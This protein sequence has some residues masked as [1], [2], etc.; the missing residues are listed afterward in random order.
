MPEIK[1]QFTGGKMNKDVDERL[2]PK[3][4]YRDAMNIQVSTSEGSDVGAVQN[5]LG[6]KLIDGLGFLSGG[7]TCVGAI[8]D[9]KN[10]AL[11]WFVAEHTTNFTGNSINSKNLILQ[12]K[13]GVVTPV[14]VDKVTAEI[15][16]GA[17]MLAP[18]PTSALTIMYL[19]PIDPG[20]LELVPG[21]Y[22]HE[23]V[24]DINSDGNYSPL[25][26][27]GNVI[28]VNYTTGAV[29]IDVGFTQLLAEVFNGQI[30]QA[31]FYVSSNRGSVLGFDKNN[32][33]T[34]I[35][36]ID[37]MLFW[38]DGI[39]EPK[40]INI[41]RSIAGTTNIDFST[42]LI[43]DA[44]GITLGSNILAREE[45][46]TV[47]KK[48]PLRA[49]YLYMKAARGGNSRGTTSYNFNS[50]SPSDTIT[51][52]IQPFS[53]SS[54]NYQI[55]DVLLL[56]QINNPVAA[57]FPVT[58]FDIRAV[59]ISISGA[60]VN[61]QVLSIPN[62]L[63]FGSLVFVVDLDE[64]YDKLYALKF[65]R[66]A[67]RYKYEDNEYSS[68]GPFSEVAFMPGV[69]D[70][71][72]NKGYNLG[73]ENK[74]R[75]L[76]I[77][78]LIPRNIPMDVVE[79]DILYRESDSPNIYIVDEIKPSDPQWAADSYKITSETIKAA[80]PSNQLLR[81]WD[82]VPKKALAQEMTGNRIVY[83]N[84]EQN[85]DMHAYRPSLDVA[86]LQRVP[87]SNGW[88]VNSFLK[89]IKSLRDYQ[90][91]VVFSDAYGR[92]TPV[93]TDSAGSIKVSK[94]AASKSHQIVLQTTTPPPEWAKYQ[95][96]YIKETSTEYYN[97]SLD[98]Y[99]EAEDGNVW[100]SFPSSDR[101]KVDLDSSLYLKKSFNSAEAGFSTEKY[102]IIDIN[103]EAPEFIKTRRSILGK[104]DNG[105]DN[106]L[107]TADAN[108]PVRY[109]DEFT[110]ES[111]PLKNTILENF[112]KRHNSAD[113]GVGGSGGGAVV[114]N[115]LF[116]RITSYT[117]DDVGVYSPG[118]LATN[119]YEIDNVKKSEDNEEYI[120]RVKEPFGL[121]ATWTNTGASGN[122]ASGMSTITNDEVGLQFEIGQD[123]VQ[124]KA[125][126]QGRF[127][128]KIL[129]DTAVED[130]IIA[131]AM[132]Q[133]VE[134]LATAR[135]GYLKDFTREDLGITNSTSSTLAAHAAAISDFNVN[136]PDGN[137]GNYSNPEPDGVPVPTDSYWSWRA[138][139]KIQSKLNTLESRWVIDEAFATGEEPFWGSAGYV[140]SNEQADVMWGSYSTTYGGYH[141]QSA[142]SWTL[143][144]N[145]T[146]GPWNP[147]GLASS[148]VQGLGHGTNLEDYEYFTV[149]NGVTDHTIDISY[150]GTGRTK[151]QGYADIYEDVNASASDWEALVWHQKAWSTWWEISGSSTGDALDD[152]ARVFADMLQPGAFLRFKNDPNLIVYEIESVKKIFKLNYAEGKED[153]E[154]PFASSE[155]GDSSIPNGAAPGANEY[156]NRSHLNRRI[157]YRLKLTAP[158]AGDIIGTNGG[159]TGP[160]YD[161]LFGDNTNETNISGVFCPIEIVTLHSI[162][163][164]GETTMPEDPA[165]FE[166]V[167]K[168]DTGLDIYHEASDTM[169]IDLAFDP[170]AFAPRG[171]RVSTA[172]DAL[173]GN[174]ISGPATVSGWE[175]NLLKISNAYFM[176]DFL[177]Q[178][179]LL[180][181]TRPDGSY[182][183]AIIQGGL[184]E[185]IP[186]QP[187]SSY[188]AYISQAVGGNKI[189]IGWHNCYAFGNGVESNRIRDTFNKPFIDNGAKVSTTLEGGYEKEHRRYGLIY[190]GAYN[191]TSS[192]NNL[193]QFIAAEKITKDIN[194]IYGSIQK[195]YS[196]WGQGGDLIALCEDRILKILANKDALFNADG[197]PQLTSTNN[198]LGQAIPYSGEY[199]ISENPESFASEAYRIYFTDKV[200][201]A[202]MRLSMDGLTPISNHGMKDWFRDNLKLSNKIIGSYDD[203]KDEYNLTLE[204]DPAVID[205]KKP[206]YPTTVTFRED[207]KGWVSFKSFTPE[208]AISCA[209]EYYTFEK[210]KMWQ[211]HI[212]SAPCNTFNNVRR[213]SSLVAILNDIPGSIK[214][215]TTLN[216]EGTQARVSRSLDAA[217][218]DVQDGEYYNL[219]KINGWFVDY[220]ETE[221]DSGGV[222]EFRKKEH[223]WF[224]YIKGKEGVITNFVTNDFSGERFANQGLGVLSSDATQS[225]TTGCMDDTMFNYDS[226][227]DF[228][229]GSCI[230]I[231]FGCLDPSATNFNPNANT[232]NNS[233]II[234]GCIDNVTINGCGINCLGALNFDSSANEDDGSCVYCIFGCTDDTMF[235][236]SSLATCDDGSCIPYIPGCTDSFNANATNYDPLANIEDGSCGYYGCTDPAAANFLTGVY[237]NL[238]STNGI[239]GESTACYDMTAGTTTGGIPFSDTLVPPYPSPTTNFMVMINSNPNIVGQLAFIPPC[240]TEEDSSCVYMGCGDENACNYDPL[241]LPNQTDSCQYCGIQTAINYDGADIE[242]SMS[243]SV[244]DNGPCDQDSVS[245]VSIA[246]LLPNS[247][248]QFC[249]QVMAA[250]IVTNVTYNSYDIAW[251]YPND[252][253]GTPLTLTE[254]ARFELT[255][256]NS[257]PAVAAVAINYPSSHIDPN[258][259]DYGLAP[260]V[261]GSGIVGDPFTITINNT[262][263]LPLW[264]PTVTPS[265]NYYIN[266]T[267]SCYQAG[268]S[269]NLSQALITTPII[270]MSGYVNWS[271]DASTTHGSD[272]VV[273][274]PPEPIWVIG[275]TDAAAFNYNPDANVDD[276]SCCLI[277]GC[278]ADAVGGFSNLNMPPGACYDDGSC[279]PFVYGC[280]IY[281]MFNYDPLVTF[282]DG[283]CEAVVEGCTVSNYAEYNPDA[284]TNDGSCLTV[285]VNGCM[286]ECATNYN[287]YATNH[288]DNSCVIVNGCT[289]PGAI[290]YTQG[291]Y[292]CNTVPCIYPGCTDP[293]ASNYDPTAG[294]YDVNNPDNSSCTYPSGC[295]P[296]SCTPFGIFSAYTSQASSTGF[297]INYPT[298][299]AWNE[300][301][302]GA[303]VV[304]NL[305]TGDTTPIA[306]TVGATSEVVATTL[307]AGLTY[308]TVTYM[309]FGG[310]TGQQV[311]AT[312]NN[313]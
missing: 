182:T 93:L 30:P 220:I 9:E 125:I 266:V 103:N 165:V 207:V 65:P 96:F 248:C 259:S 253:F 20:L 196:G 204:G 141:S 16:G 51:I 158:N 229:D 146:S 159:S 31:A 25:E 268:A 33:I 199:G 206:G 223:K 264:I 178:N 203:R 130:N 129:M 262:S 169:P 97:L 73:M 289:D 8:A 310:G 311:I 131:P 258:G 52:S 247:T 148:I 26:F 123:T 101:N 114:N 216:Y 288:D 297:T 157:T 12:Y 28:S 63:A 76:R 251:L 250:P 234:P 54:V 173:G 154:Y 111:D 280:P 7:A 77:R 235:N 273:Q 249:E 139:H 267:A 298:N 198:V 110:V 6:N 304:L 42:R 151:Y 274:T 299:E 172:D 27:Q 188:Y 190:S 47:V 183:T 150:I 313:S 218:V 104:I 137:P 32:I 287:P 40:K 305:P 184:G 214:S 39:T 171:T 106:R 43:N 170:I 2:V 100:L 286:T 278:P 142:L 219:A 109:E 22:I 238:S 228:D 134:V 242:C 292:V 208:N 179:Q 309:C 67:Y 55:N 147:S 231:A 225:S 41:P 105:N 284:N 192:V 261:S 29:V 197:N 152:E 215:F 89:T 15:N 78:K 75:E 279:T 162:S 92:Q 121:D 237:D 294:N 36:I 243:E 37:D 285:I 144:H 245:Y 185:L 84:Y 217:G 301:V 124:N 175:G 88:G 11:Y 140:D 68:I 38:T 145:A 128:V 300:C 291:N 260:A 58:E 210:G 117:S 240:A 45:H 149:G 1:N 181:F 187:D 119:W 59:I 312:I 241:V 177:Y 91:G 133:T 118:S 143:D 282:D 5:I 35:N 195:L 132:Y 69:F 13:S 256:N 57:N 94:L 4:E 23:I 221:Q 53:S 21:S 113:S 246:S 122:L 19:D 107:F 49:P 61:V 82:N 269:T 189:G 265:S 230:E 263:S 293:N 201:G 271:Y 62:N 102:K 202:V 98:K 60:T 277:A 236:F 95:K 50:V 18:G 156:F 254:V 174:A 200:R 244:C 44:Q 79:I 153:N 283:S 81:A 87:L 224:N 99:F 116:V 80:V 211:H 308:A 127:F 276:G 14:F 34:G 191:S 108:L 226:A 232:T 239:T 56:K 66:F 17:G 72:P 64:F 46:I 270:G 115:P 120:I 166:T 167:P 138:W 303:E 296:G 222:T 126:F 213:D 161:P 90:V 71:S 295:N 10:D 255:I 281:G 83:G 209:N 168:E 194:P 186:G 85:Y 252:N 112:H 257:S 70:F 48:A 160:G 302:V 24:M 233:C 272:V 176:E 3:G 193:N 180:T 275:C 205:R 212:E 136:G 163:T 155:I 164:G 306:L 86:L 135:C 307:P 290:N 74:L 227:A